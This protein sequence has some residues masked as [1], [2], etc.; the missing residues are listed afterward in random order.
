MFEQ[1][2]FDPTPLLAAFLH[3][4][5][6]PGHAGDIEPVDCLA[7]QASIRDYVDELRAGG[8]AL[9]PAGSIRFLQQLFDDATQPSELEERPSDER[10]DSRERAH[11]QTWLILRHTDGRVERGGPYQRWLA[12][13]LLA[14]LGYYHDPDVVAAR[15]EGE[16]EWMDELLRELGGQAA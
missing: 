16:P 6:C 10:N 13:L 11:S 1:R 3:P 5:V 2:P 12:E 9:V 7:V 8:L 14:D 4:R 15:L